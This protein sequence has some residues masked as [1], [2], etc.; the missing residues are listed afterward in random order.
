[1]RLI[2]KDKKELK[3]KFYYIQ[4]ASVSDINLVPIEWKRL[5]RIYPELLKKI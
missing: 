1:M 3:T 4:L 5:S 2:K